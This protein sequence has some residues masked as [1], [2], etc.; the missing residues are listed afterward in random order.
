MQ[1]KLGSRRRAL[2][3]ASAAVVL[4]FLGLLMPGCAIDT[5]GYL[6]DPHAYLWDGR[7]VTELPNTLGGSLSEAHDVN[8]W[9]W[10]V[11]WADDENGIPRAV[12][13]KYGKMYRLPSI[14]GGESAALAINDL[15]QVVGWESDE[16]YSSH[17][18]LWSLGKAC[19]LAKCTWTSSRAWDI[20]NLGQVVGSFTRDAVD[21]G[22]VVD[23]YTTE[24]A[25]HPF[26]WRCGLVKEFAEAGEA[27]VVNALGCIGG[28]VEDDGDASDP[29]LH[30][31]LR[32]TTLPEIDTEQELNSAVEGLND[33]LVAVG[34]SNH[35]GELDGLPVAVPSA[36]SWSCGTVTMLPLPEGMDFSVARDI[37]LA[38]DIA[39][40]VGTYPVLPTVD[41]FGFPAN[42]SSYGLPVRAVIWSRGAVTTIPSLGDGTL[43]NYSNAINVKGHVVG[44]SE[45]EGGLPLSSNRVLSSD[46]V[47][48]GAGGSGGRATMLLYD[49]GGVLITELNDQTT[50]SVRSVDELLAVLAQP[51]YANTVRIV[52][53]LES[54]GSGG[55]NTADWTFLWE[56]GVL[57]TLQ[58]DPVLGR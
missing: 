16:S 5:H 10:A 29:W 57:K 2:V 11:G 42:S 43:F 28:W 51:A 41:G 19:D 55:T 54:Y 50:P 17:A 18:V 7:T 34:W 49:A 1:L 36:V 15:G 4:V 3:A 6:A 9:D 53:R 35:A 38:G 40:E 32:S 27:Y 48:L 8:A 44:A 30:K 25:I 20:N 31:R 52:L 22:Q 21:N 45:K 37:N 23:R 47:G 26:S 46:A 58:G 39:G 13:W 33:C 12:M 56:D 14:W 24:G